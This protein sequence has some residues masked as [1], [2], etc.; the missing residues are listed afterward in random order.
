MLC[1]PHELCRLRIIDNA[2]NLVFIDNPDDTVQQILN[3]LQQKEAPFHSADRDEVMEDLYNLVSK[4]MAFE[5]AGDRQTL[6]RLQV[7][8]LDQYRVK[9]NDVEISGDWLSEVPKDY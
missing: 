7:N 2:S 5:F 1:R 9:V 6:P 4:Y 8:L 3:F